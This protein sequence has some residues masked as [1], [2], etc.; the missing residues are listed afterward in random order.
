LEI[1]HWFELLFQ[2]FVVRI[3]IEAL[4][5]ATLFI[6]GNP[7]AGCNCTINYSANI[8]EVNRNTTTLYVNTLRSVNRSPIVAPF[9]RAA[10]MN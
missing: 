8:L 3:N 5:V 2:S 10:Q 7:S 6:I 4:K 1:G 9:R